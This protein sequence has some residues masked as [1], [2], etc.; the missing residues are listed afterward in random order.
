MEWEL[1]KKRPICPQICERLCVEIASGALAPH[2]R[3]SSVREL[4]VR[5]GVN[6]NTIQKSLEQLEAKGLL[7]SIRGSGWYVCEEQDAARAMVDNV[8]ADRVR[9]FFEDMQVL[10]LSQEDVKS[11]VKEWE[12]E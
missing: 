2:E 9:T 7:Y 4:A 5:L 1:D 8:I 10:G 12:R 11:Y 3:L 6:P